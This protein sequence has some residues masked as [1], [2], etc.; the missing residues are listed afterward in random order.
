MIDEWIADP[1]KPNPY[2]L[3]DES[4]GE[5]FARGRSHWLN[6]LTAGPSEAQIHLALKKDEVQEVVTG[7]G[8]LHGSS[9]TSLLTAR[10]QLEQSQ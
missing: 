10:L 8:K 4:E 9:V 5:L 1:T 7:G 6:M 3:E 2:L